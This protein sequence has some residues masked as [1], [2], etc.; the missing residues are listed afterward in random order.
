MGTAGLLHMYSSI[1]CTD[2]LNE[3]GHCVHPAALNTYD[4]FSPLL[5]IFELLSGSGRAAGGDGRSSPSLSS[6]PVPLPLL[7]AQRVRAPVSTAG[8]RLGAGMAGGQGA[9]TTGTGGW[10]LLFR[11]TFHQ[12]YADSGLDP[13]MEAEQQGLV[14]PALPIKATLPQLCSTCWFQHAGNAGLPTCCP[15]CLCAV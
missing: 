1:L 13:F 6:L 8:G 14:R 3:S 15:C 4:C 10:Q 12:S 5:S 7:Q 9:A 2:A 11:K